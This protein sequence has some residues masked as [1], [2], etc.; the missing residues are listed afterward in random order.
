M[1]TNSGIVILSEVFLALYPILIKL[2]PTNLT[3]QLVAR[4]LVFSGLG[5]AF[6]KTTDIQESWFTFSEH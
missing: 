1:D 5:F 6:A 3:T 2:V 4:F